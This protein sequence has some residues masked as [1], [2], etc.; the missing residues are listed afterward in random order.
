MKRRYLYVLLYCAPALLAAAIISVLLFGAAAGT[1]WLFA[2]GD[3][4][5]PASVDDTLVAL[6]LLVCAGLWLALI[7]L[8][9]LAGKKQEA[10][11][12]FNTRPVA[13]A[14]GATVLLAL[15]IVWH[16]WGVGNIGAKSESLLCSDFCRDKGYAAS[17]LPPR[18]AGT[19]TCS[20]F[21][22]RGR[23]SATVPMTDLR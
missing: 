5:W 18:D 19:R 4:P 6:F 11:P 21:D 20:C 8:A 17:G 16:Q 12:G 13:G 7:S 23:E 14:V 3:S 1:L 10:N 2:F 9:Y 15:L 22:A